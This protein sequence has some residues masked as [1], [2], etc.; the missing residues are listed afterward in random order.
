MLIQPTAGSRPVLKD[1][2]GGRWRIDVVNP[3]HLI[4]TATTTT[5]PELLLAAA[6]SR[7]GTSGTGNVLR[8]GSLPTNAHFIAELATGDRLSGSYRLNSGTTYAAT[9]ASSAFPLLSTK[10]VASSKLTATIVGIAK[11]HGTPVT[12]A[13]VT[14]TSPS[15]SI[16]ITPVAASYW[17]VAVHRAATITTEERAS[18]VTALAALQGRII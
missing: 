6:I 14:G 5:A 3:K 1:D 9:S 7:T 4:S 11:D 18:I 2:G 16:A 10:Y 17:G 13:A 15:Q 12:A 8:S